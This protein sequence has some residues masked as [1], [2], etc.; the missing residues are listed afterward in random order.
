MSYRLRKFV[1]WLLVLALPLQSFAAVTGGVCACTSLFSMTA[2]SVSTDHTLHEG[3]ADVESEV[4][5]L[6]E[7]A[8]TQTCH[9]PEPSKKQHCD[10]E[11]EHSADKTSCGAC[12]G[13]CVMHATLPVFIPGPDT[14]SAPKV[15][16][17]A[18]PNIFTDHVTLTPKRPPRLHSA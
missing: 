16:A 11:N 12:S 10:S 18:I 1:F 2:E 13:C 4:V 7:N 6:A 8:D 17:V 14:V 5:A 15:S 9:T 3:A